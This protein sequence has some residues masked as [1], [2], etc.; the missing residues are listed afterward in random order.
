MARIKKIQAEGSTIYPATITNAIKDPTT[1]ESLH[2]ILAEKADKKGKYPEFISGYTF[3]IIGDGQATE[4]EFSYRPTAGEDRNVATTKIYNDDIKYG[5]AQIKTLKGNSEVWNQLV[6]TDT[7]SVELTANHKYITNIGGTIS[8]QSPPSATTINVSG[9]TDK[10]TDLTKMFGAGNE[11]TTVEEFY[12]R[13]PK[14]VD[15]NAYNEGEIVDGNY[16][17][18][19]TTGVNQYNGTFAK[20]IGGLTYYLGGTYTSSGFTTTE[21]GATEVI[22]IP[23]NKLYTPT[24]NGYIYAQG[25]DICI[26][27]VWPEYGEFTGY[28]PYKPYVRYLS[29]IVS[30]YFPNGMRSAGKARDEIRFN[31]TTQ[32]WEAVQNVGVVDL[33][34]LMWTLTT[35][36]RYF[37]T[38]TNAKP[39][40]SDDERISGILSDKY[41]LSTN[42]NPSNIDD[43][44]M[45]KFDSGTSIRIYVRDSA[46]ADVASFTTAMKGVMLNYEFAEPGVTE[47]TENVNLVY[48]VSDLGTE[49]LLVLEGN[50]SAPLVADIVYEPNVLASSKQIPDILKRLASLE[51]ALASATT[52]TNIETTE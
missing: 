21:G 14:G 29:E 42:V 2:N 36:N 6:N 27:L 16:G 49:E 48:D 11:P 17:A 3:E 52:T 22:S 31:S 4:E 18:I 26:S 47:I 10:V 50:Q 33:G 35:N 38:L 32:K 46:Y 51:A 7:T 24:Q 19:K 23:S 40:K 25:S 5:A 1:G 12:Q 37:A 39:P 44:S 8:H 34:D 28:E 45:I 20:V 41:S 43:K 9:D 15:L 30:K 13:L